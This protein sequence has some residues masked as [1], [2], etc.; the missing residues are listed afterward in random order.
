M[1]REGTNRGSVSKMQSC[2][3]DTR[4]TPAIGDAPRWYGKNMTSTRA[5][6]RWDRHRQSWLTSTGRIVVGRT[7]T[8]GSRRIASRSKR[9]EQRGPVKMTSSMPGIRAMAADSS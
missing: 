2:S 9:R 3:S 4:G 7:S 5:R 6:R 8:P 1:R